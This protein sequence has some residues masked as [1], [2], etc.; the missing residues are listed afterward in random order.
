MTMMTMM[1]T[2]KRWLWCM[3]LLMII[4]MLIV[5]TIVV[6]QAGGQ[7][8]GS[9]HLR[10]VVQGILAQVQQRLKTKSVGILLKQLNPVKS[11]RIHLFQ[12]GIK[13]AH[14]LWTNRQCFQET[15]WRGFCI[16]LTLALGMTMIIAVILMMGKEIMN[17]MLSSRQQEFSRRNSII[18]W[19][20]WSASLPLA[21]TRSKDEAG[22]AE[23]GDNC[24]IARG[25]LSSASSSVEL[26]FCLQ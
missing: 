20:F 19:V 9:F 16:I 3:L 11:N 8:E 17:N 13:P 21:G 5:L 4:V 2:T 25:L 6:S 1:M 18:I 23:G 12:G 10:S 7:L 26:H 22:K 15:C 24:Q 14:K